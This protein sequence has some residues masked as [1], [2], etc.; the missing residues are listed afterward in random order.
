MRWTRAVVVGE[1]SSRYLRTPMRTNGSAAVRPSLVLI[2]WVRLVEGENPLGTADWV[3]RDGS[4]SRSRRMRD[5][6]REGGEGGGG[7]S[8]DPAE[9][10][11]A[12]GRRS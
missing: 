11:A 3:N 10:V 9:G 1:L 2:T 6:I 12:Y 8:H 4:G 5:R 7:D